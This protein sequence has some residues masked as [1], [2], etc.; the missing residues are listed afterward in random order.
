MVAPHIRFGR[1]LNVIF[2]T[3]DIIPDAVPK[4]FPSL[5]LDQTRIFHLLGDKEDYPAKNPRLKNH[6]KTVKICWQL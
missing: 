1:F 5:F 6:I 4:G 2:L 3:R